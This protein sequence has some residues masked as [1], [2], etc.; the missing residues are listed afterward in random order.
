MWFMLPERLR[1]AQDC[2][3]STRLCVLQGIFGGNAHT[4]ALQT[5]LEGMRP[6]S[7]AT[8]F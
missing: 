5:S 7:S 8:A 4:L 3:L 2:L 6:N 1:P